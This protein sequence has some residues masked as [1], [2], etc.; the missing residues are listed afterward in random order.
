M[1]EDKKNASATGTCVLRWRQLIPHVRDNNFRAAVYISLEIT[2]NLLRSIGL[3]LLA[4]VSA[5]CATDLN[6]NN[7]QRYYEASLQAE[8][9]RNWVGAYEGYRRALINFRSA[10]APVKLISAATYNLGRM[11]GYICKY[12]EAEK[13]LLESVSLEEK[14]GAPDPVNLT[15]RWSELARLYD[16]RGQ[17][18]RAAAYYAR[19][20]PELERLGVAS[21]D[22]IG[23]ANYLEAYG[24]ALQLSGENEASAQPSQRAAT[25]RTENASRAALFIPVTYKSVCG[26]RVP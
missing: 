2:M 5:G 12:D 17:P 23:F 15:K 13:L 1:E 22:P 11:A 9:Q 19:S 18:N 24:S 4:C 26:A 16:D 25:L 7:A 21:S 8:A 14:T 10:G 6:M 3:V 20:I